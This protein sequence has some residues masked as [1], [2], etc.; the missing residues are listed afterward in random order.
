MRWLRCPRAELGEEV[1]GW[2]HEKAPVWELHKTSR[3]GATCFGGLGELH[4][5][6]PVWELHKTSR[7]G[8]TCFGRVGEL[9]E[10][11][12]AVSW[13]GAFFFF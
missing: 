5:K 4:E 6:G 1:W 12:L 2:L 11:F 7:V 10:T 3:V 13:L 8:A 9:H